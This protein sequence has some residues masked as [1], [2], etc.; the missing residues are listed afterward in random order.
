MVTKNHHFFLCSNGA[1]IIGEN[2][3]S[4]KPLSA[5]LT[6]DQKSVRRSSLRAT[7]ATLSQGQQIA[8]D[9]HTTSGE[10]WLTNK[11]SINRPPAHS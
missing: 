2:H 3:M 5:I 1:L 11:R 4:V 8:S 10:S 9:G 7:L 6:T